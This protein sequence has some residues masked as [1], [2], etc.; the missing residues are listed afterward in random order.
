MKAIEM[1]SRTYIILSFNDRSIIPF[2]PISVSKP[3]GKIEISGPRQDASTAAAKRSGSY[4]R[5]KRI[6]SRTLA[7]MIHGTSC[8]SE[9]QIHKHKPDDINRFDESIPCAW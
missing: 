2:S 7:F 5:P 9:I 3:L 4:G 1:V 8:T 6:F